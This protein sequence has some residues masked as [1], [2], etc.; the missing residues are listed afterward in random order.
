MSY[1]WKT[2]QAKVVRESQNDPRSL[3][4]I[5]RTYELY[6]NRN[7]VFPLFNSVNFRDIYLIN[8]IK[9]ITS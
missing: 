5:A 9:H 3:D 7:L 1:E 4:L 2:P 6:R 8:L